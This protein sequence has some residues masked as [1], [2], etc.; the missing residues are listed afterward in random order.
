MIPQ[1]Y[2]IEWRSTSPWAS[3]A[4]VEQDLVISRALVEMF[5]SEL[6]KQGLAFRGGTALHKLYI[7]PQVRYS[8]DIDL[9]QISPEPIKP[10]LM[11]IRNRL[12]FLGTK[13]IVKQHIHNNTVLYRFESE[14][15]PVVNLRLKI[16]INTREHFNILGLQSYPFSV[17][18]SWFSG[19]ATI[20]T[21]KVEELLGTKLRAL[22]QRRKGRDLFDLFWALKQTN[23][24][25]ND[26]LECYRKY[27]S[28]VVDVLPTQKQFLVNMEEKMQDNEFLSDMRNIIRP[29]IEYS[30]TEAWNLVRTKLVELV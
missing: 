12:S 7:S 21:Y 9:V 16:E 2:I 30:P 3:D 4:Q 11:E 22:Y 15:P 29:G 24:N 19:S 18:N 8:E 27:M 6:L 26:I 23:L 20:N 14:I 10:I 25:L 17:S 13:R 1:R 5:Q 28:F